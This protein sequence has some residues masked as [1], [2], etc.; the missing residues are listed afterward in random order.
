MKKEVLIIWHNGCPSGTIAVKNGSIAKMDRTNGICKME[1]GF[2][3]FTSDGECR[4]ALE[5]DN[6]ALNPGAASTIVHVRT[7]RN[8]F[9]FFLRDVCSEYPV[10]I[11]EYGVIVTSAGDMRTYHGICAAIESGATL[12]RLETIENQPEESFESAASHT[13]NLH[14]F[15]W[16]GLSRDIRI[17][18][19]GSRTITYAHSN[20]EVWDWIRP[21]Y[22]GHSVKLPE[23]G[24]TPVKYH[25][26]AGRGLGCEQVLERW[27]E[28]G[29]LPI[30][31]SR[32]M[33]DDVCYETKMFVTLEKSR[34]KPENIHGTHYLVA[35]AHSNSSMMTEEQ[36]K[37]KDAILKKEIEQEE[38]TVAYIRINAINLAKVP[39]YC[40]VRIPQPYV[41]FLPDMSV[42][43]PVYNSGKGLGSF[44]SDRVYLVAALNGKPVPQKEMAVLLKPGEKAEYVFKIPHVPVTEERAEALANEDFDKR[45]TECREYWSQKLACAAK[46]CIPEKRIN[47]M[48]KA[49]ILHLD[50]VCYGNE[51][52]GAVAATVGHYSP[53][54]SESSP[55][56]QY[57]ESIGKSDLARRSIMYFFEKQ[58]DD[59][60]M[61]NF[62]G[63][64]LETGAVLWNVGEHYRYTKDREWIKSI[65]G[66]IIKACDYLIA[67]RDKNKKEELRG[68]GY[69]MIEGKVADPEDPYHSYM[70]NGFAYLGL[71]RSSEV[72]EAIGVEDALRIEKEAN[73][74]LADIRIALAESIAS[75]PAIPL[76][77]GRWC[78]SVSPWVESIG[79]VSL[80]ADEGDAFT[81][82]TFTTRDAICG[83]MYLLLQEVV[84]PKEVYGDFILRS[85]TEL[86]YLRNTVFSQ[87]YYSPHPYA[88]LKR[89]EVK[90]FLKEYYNGVS[91]LADRE[92]YTFWEHY[93]HVSP[94]KTHE[95]GWFLMRC[96][97]MLYM[98]EDETLKLLQGVPRAWLEDG[99]KISL[100]GMKTYFGD[101][102]LDV[103]SAVNT[104]R[105]KVSVKIDAPASQLPRRVV[106]RIPHPFMQKA[107]GTTAGVYEPCTESVVVDGFCGTTDIEIEFS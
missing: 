83:S 70:L 13:R 90:A 67:W 55:I 80:Y 84:D 11:P 2:F 69:G 33:D 89:G 73:A 48:M 35:D 63:Y 58:H 10:Y 81:H 59:G 36:K 65:K 26:F 8:P 54:G 79:P 4:L 104:G 7:S 66:G 32:H 30:L 20:P 82:A 60:F 103:E 5:V 61:Q 78:P 42:V 62:G 95:E 49:G 57:L 22:H 17:F 24:N 87:P 19:A 107:S 47:E 14:G 91:G 41:P 28:E 43:K 77:N 85:F 40:W 37:R 31:N 97:W 39:R 99:K 27:I 64:M 18:E 29:C 74:L 101:L 76:G 96:R 44:S 86:F 68:K 12:S 93:H 46:F 75:C 23:L 72:L 92:T 16:L 15:V 56:I 50:L 98:E 21:K 100:H 94:H 3:S 34:L 71:K 88:N 51:P 53:I 52:D 38:E 6:A 9:S 102:H 106:I 1:D 25:Y 45:L 105:V